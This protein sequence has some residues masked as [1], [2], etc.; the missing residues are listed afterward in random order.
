MGDIFSYGCSEA[1]RDFG[2]Q[3]WGYA[4]VGLVID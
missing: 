2:G 4:A 3:R 1:N